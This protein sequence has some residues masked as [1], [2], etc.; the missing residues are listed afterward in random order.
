MPSLQHQA[1]E[2]MP[3]G[4]P[5]P[6][7]PDYLW[8]MS[9]LEP[10]LTVKQEVEHQDYEDNPSYGRRATA[11]T[12][13]P[14]NMN[15]V[16]GWLQGFNGGGDADNVSPYFHNRNSMLGSLTNNVSDQFSSFGNYGTM[17]GP[18]GAFS[19]LGD[20]SS[21]RDPFGH[22][23][24][25]NRLRSLSQAHVNPCYPLIDA[26]YLFP[27]NPSAVFH[28]GST[29]VALSTDA[30]TEHYIQ[31]ISGAI[32]KEVLTKPKQLKKAVKSRQSL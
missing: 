3:L 27:P 7:D 4:V 14:P 5:F 29:L 21:H 8:K 2:D 13:A 22:N 1:L 19:A 16:S 32:A 31:D 12:S 20:S 26:N 24:D 23:P 15:L 30:D 9:E 28:A 10:L 6:S 11:P 18:F 25:Y 17:T